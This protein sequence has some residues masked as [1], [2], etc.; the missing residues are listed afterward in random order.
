MADD[1]EVLAKIERADADVK[2]GYLLTD[3]PFAEPKAK[4]G[5]GSHPRSAAALD[6]HRKGT[7]LGGP[8]IRT[9]SRCRRL[10]VKGRNVC[11]FHGGAETVKARKRAK[12]EPVGSAAATARHE[13]KKL[14]RSDALPFALT[15]EALYRAAHEGARVRLT[16]LPEFDRSAL[17]HK[18][19]CSLLLWEAVRGW[20]I[21]HETGDPLPWA[22]AVRKGRALG[23]I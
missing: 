7:Q 20:M 2:A 4:T 12:G 15:Q 10:A 16:E 23:L 21:R 1:L 8:N 13:V 18:Q 11:Y 9:C 6:A 22:E 3:N 17:V 14:I 19:A 5:K